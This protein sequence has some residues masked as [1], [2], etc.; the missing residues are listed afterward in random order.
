[1]SSFWTATN[2]IY[3]RLKCWLSWLIDWLLICFRAN[4]QKQEWVNS[5]INTFV[6][7]HS[8]LFVGVSRVSS[9]RRHEKRQKNAVLKGHSIDFTPKVQLRR[10]RQ[11]D[12]CGHGFITRLG[13]QLSKIWENNLNDVTRIM[14]DWAWD[15][16]I[17]TKS[18]CYQLGK[19]V[20]IHQKQ[21]LW[22]ESCIMGSVWPMLEV[23]IS[24][25]PLLRL[26]SLTFQICLSQPPNLSKV[27]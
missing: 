22:W 10:H 12:A 19:N 11:H 26:W 15:F 20:A 2:D 16:K 25:P 23:R 3:Y 5:H 24:Q 6:W 17:G 18:L 21:G 27:Q 4:N 9:P 8:S 14:T 7:L 1:M 13:M